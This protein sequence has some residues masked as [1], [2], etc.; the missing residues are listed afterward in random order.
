MLTLNKA[1]EFLKVETIEDDALISSLI[2]A[3]DLYI[4]NAC[5]PNYPQNDLTDLAQRL[6]VCHWYEHREAI[7]KA[8]QMAFSL[9]S[10]L[11]QIKF[12]SG[13]NPQ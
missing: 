4:K 3:S 2:L 13:V 11:R 9:D 6:L 7:G 5:D 12:T 1:K 8:D 10:I